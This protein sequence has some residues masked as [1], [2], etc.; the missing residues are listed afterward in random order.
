MAGPRGAQ[1]VLL[2]LAAGLLALGLAG[3]ARWSSHPPVRAVPDAPALE[4]RLDLNRA[5]ASD[6]ETL[7]GI[8]PAL[9]ARILAL[10]RE[11][12][13]F[14]SVEELG[15]V[16]RIGARLLASLRPLVTVGD[17]ATDRE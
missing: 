13:G 6:L 8:G 10:R 9:A 5:S 16:P 3:P 12:G 14:R 15:G 1:R 4:V 11:R 17:R 2:A 7:P